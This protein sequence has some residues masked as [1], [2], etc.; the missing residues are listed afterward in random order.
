MKT[1]EI[2]EIKESVLK[3]TLKGDRTYS[4]NEVIGKDGKS[5]RFNTNTSMPENLFNMVFENGLLPYKEL[6]PATFGEYSWVEVEL[7]DEYKNVK[8]T[9]KKF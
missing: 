5:Y 7:P 9:L 4:R 8:K 6:T 1:I 2:A 3:E